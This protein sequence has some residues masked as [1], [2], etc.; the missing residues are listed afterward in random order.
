MPPPTPDPSTTL[1]ARIVHRARADLTAATAIVLTLAT[2]L[3]VIG[4]TT[5]S[6][7]TPPSAITIVTT[8]TSAESRVSL[9]NSLAT[10]L[11]NMAKQSNKTG[12]ATVRMVTSSTST[13]TTT[14][15]TPLRPGNQVQHARAEADR[16]IAAS[17][18]EL[19]TTVSNARADRPGLDL[20]GLLDRASQ[21]SGDLHIVSSGISTE[22]PMDLRVIGWNMNV[23]SVI[24]SIARQGRIPNL[25]GRHMTFHGLGIAAGSQQG[26]PPFARSMIERLWT[27][28]CERARAASCVIAHDAPA[29]VAPVATMP[30]PVV[31]VPDAVTEGGCPVWASLSDAVLHFSPES[32]ALPANADDALRPIVEAAARCSVQTIDVT[33]HIADTGTGDGRGNLAQ[34]RASAVADRLLALGLPSTVLGTVTGRDAREPVIPNFTDGRFDEAKA[35]QNRRVEI[36]FHR[37]GR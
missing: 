31:P 8:A 24:D 35:T 7:D 13:V 25:S 29:A 27:G 20:L 22:A 36:A 17:V 23:D 16:Q 3:G 9:P 15:L 2:L 21:L 6:A 4:C 12:G 14:D 18:L 19:A 34:R 37:T 32:T 26:L 33:G 1:T 30:V 10:E 28:I 11:V 5:S